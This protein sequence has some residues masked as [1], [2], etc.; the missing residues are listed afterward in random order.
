[1]LAS[2]HDVDVSAAF[3]SLRRHA[4]HTT[5]SSTMLRLMSSRERCSSDHRFETRWHDVRRW[6]IISRAGIPPGSP[7]RP[8]IGTGALAELQALR[9]KIG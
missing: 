6:L 3:E 1:V 2:S 7:V 5:A 4:R 9:R 8:V